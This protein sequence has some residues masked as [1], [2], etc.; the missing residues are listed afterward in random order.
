[1]SID[2][3]DSELIDFNSHWKFCLINKND[4]I[5]S[6][7]NDKNN[8][9]SSINL[10]HIIINN[11]LFNYYYKKEFNLN[12]L[13]EDIYLYLKLLNEENKS[14]L[15]I[16]IWINQNEILT[17]YLFNKNEK[18]KL[19][20][21]SLNLN[22]NILIISCLNNSL[23]LNIQLVFND[24]LIYTSG[25]INIDKKENDTLKYTVHLNNK[26][27]RISVAFKD[28][29]NKI[30]SPLFSSTKKNSSEIV[31]DNLENVKIPHLSI[32]ILIVG[33]RG[34]VQPFIA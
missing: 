9:W 24:K 29:K 26:D 28:I 3:E 21:E 23:S 10:P 8:H 25:Q 14:N 1:M 30:K 22:N 18:I 12:L 5:L 15:L 27:G 6:I 19:S 2:K 7:L 31:N 20:K 34:D 13:N 16:N 33:T 11:E 32:L 17:N 4:S